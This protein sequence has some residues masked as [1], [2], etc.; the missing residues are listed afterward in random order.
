MIPAF[1]AQGSVVSSTGDLTVPWPAG[2]QVDDIG[3]LFVQT[4]NQVVATPSGWTV[5]PSS[6][7]GTGTAGA[8]G[9]TRLSVFYRRATSAAEADV[10]VTDS[11]DH[12]RARIIIIRGCETSGSPF[13]TSAGDVQASAVTAVAI[14]GGTTTVAECLILA[15]VANA[16]DVSSNQTTSGGWT[17]ADLANVTRIVTGNTTSG[18]GGGFDVA[19]GEKATA[20]AFGATSV[21]LSTASAQ[22]R[23]MLALKPPGTPPPAGVT[24]GGIYSTT[25]VKATAG[26][27]SATTATLDAAAVQARV[28]IAL[29]PPSAPPANNPP[30]IAPI[31]AI[32][33]AVDGLVTFPID[34]TDLDSDPITLSLV[35]GAS[36]VPAGAALVEDEGS[37]NF[38][39]EWT[40]T[41]AQAG[42]WSFF[43]RAND[44]TDITDSPVSIT[45]VAQ[46]DTTVLELARS[47][48]ARAQT[49]VE[50]ARALADLMDLREQMNAAV[51]H[52][53]RTLVT[54]L[55]VSKA[56][57][58]EILAE[59]EEGEEPT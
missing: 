8:A 34:A 32:Q 39:F 3:L 38:H 16:T 40:P 56:Y 19:S 33:G 7:Q 6:P 46:P 43:I 51:I 28:T 31:P 48:A 44:G 22:G 15:G 9:S 20:G 35:D 4:S 2:H 26:A 55:E 12:Q 30:I 59:L 27:V 29:K 57:M 18:N 50:S 23:I 58:D 10:A 14:P 54:D 25:G 11:G 49:D 1:I 47:I 24:E 42:E 5:A 52:R 53:V 21:D 37:G 45:V 36:T 17:N 41:D 13:D